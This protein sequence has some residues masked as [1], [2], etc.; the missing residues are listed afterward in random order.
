MRH[1]G[2]PARLVNDIKML[3]TDFSAQMICSNNLTDT[4]EIKARLQTLTIS[5]YAEH[6]LDHAKSRKCRQEKD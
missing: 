1:Y 3:R 2:V 5:V 4:F 6:G